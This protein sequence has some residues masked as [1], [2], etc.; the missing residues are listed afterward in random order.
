[1]CD[2]FG[3][4]PSAGHAVAQLGEA[5]RYK[6]L[7]RTMAQELTQPLNRNEYQEY[8]LG[9]GGGG[10]CKV[11][12]CIGL[13]TLSPSCADCLEIWELQPPGTLRTCPGLYWDCFFFRG[14]SESL[15]QQ[16]ARVL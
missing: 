3:H 14:P 15:V 16:R 5:L 4:G 11:G 8:F 10:G 13:T 2:I 6:P 9:G 7:G 12:R 1:M